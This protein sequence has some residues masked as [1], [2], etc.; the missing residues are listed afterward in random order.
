MTQ[1]KT[2]MD[3]LKTGRPITDEERK[4]LYNILK[5]TDDNMI[6]FPTSDGTILLDFR[7]RETPKKVIVSQWNPDKCPSCHAKLSESL[8]DGYYS[9]P[10]FLERCPK[11]L[12]KLDWND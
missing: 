5:H 6:S 8:G 7:E 9:H 1:I 3:A 2:F 12:Q 11:C 4:D 10:T